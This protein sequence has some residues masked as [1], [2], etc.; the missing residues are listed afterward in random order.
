MLLI[1]DMCLIVSV[2]IIG[3]SSILLHAVLRLPAIARIILVALRAIDYDDGREEAQKMCLADLQ[4]VGEMV[5]G[6]TWT[7]VPTE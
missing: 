6:D 7:C 5:Q 2:S 1:S 3:Y 4:C